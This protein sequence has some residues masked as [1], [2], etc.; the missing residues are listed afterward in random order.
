MKNIRLNRFAVWFLGAVSSIVVLFGGVLVSAISTSPA[1]LLVEAS[2]VADVSPSVILLP[3]VVPDA[4]VA[5]GGVSALGEAH[6]DAQMAE[7]R[8][9]VADEVDSLAVVFHK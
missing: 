1:P 6:D 5:L 2:P 4:V 7:L 3:P 8:Q 9:M